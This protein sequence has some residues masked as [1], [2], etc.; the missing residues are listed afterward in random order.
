[1]ATA[2]AGTLLAERLR[3]ERDHNY[4]LYVD[5]IKERD[6]WKE[7]YHAAE[8]A[9]LWFDFIEDELPQGESDKPLGITVVRALGGWRKARDSYRLALAKSPTGETQE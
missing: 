9:L 5:A 1:M 3:R 7:R 6:A 2:P 8:D 4:Q